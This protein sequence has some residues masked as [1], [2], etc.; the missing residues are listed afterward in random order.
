MLITIVHFSLQSALI[1]ELE[2]LGQKAMVVLDYADSK[3]L[4]LLPPTPQTATAYTNTG[5]YFPQQQQPHATTANPFGSSNKTGPHRTPS[6]SSLKR[7]NEDEADCVAAIA[8]VLY[9][10]ALGFLQMGIEKARAYWDSKVALST[11]PA[12]SPEFNEGMSVTRNACVSLGLTCFV[13]LSC[14]MASPSLQR[15][16]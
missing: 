7:I 5:S 15:E 8:L 4:Q 13:A 6:A 1:S 2:D 9:L 14:P 3:L 11:I 16:S 10:K 12:A